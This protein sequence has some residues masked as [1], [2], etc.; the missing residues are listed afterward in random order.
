M[1]LKE[2]Q[3]KGVPVY[4]PEHNED[5]RFIFKKQTMLDGTEMDVMYRKGNPGYTM[6]E[7]IAAR[8][9][10][11]MTFSNFCPKLDPRSFEVTPG[12][13]CDRDV[14]CVLRD[15]TRIYA[16]IYR[17]ANTTEKVPVIVSWSPFGKRQSEGMGTWKLMGVPPH[18]VSQWA[19]FESPDPGYWCHQGYAIANVDP[20]GVGNSEGDSCPFTMQDGRD[21]YDFTEWVAEQEWCNGKVAY[22]GNSGV[23]M[24]IW[25]IAAEQPPHLACIAPWEGTGDMYRES[26]CVGGI[27]S[28]LFNEGI[29][30]G[31]SCNNYAEDMGNMSILHPFHDAYWES[32]T[33]RWENIRVPAYVTAGYCHFH[34]HGSIEGFR[35]I[36]STKKWLRIHREMEWPDTYHKDNVA[37]LKLFFDRYL[38]DIHNGWEFTPKI[39]TDIMDAYDFDLERNHEEREYPIA[40]TEYKKIYLDAATGTGSYTP[41]EK[42]AEIAYDP[43]KDVVSFDYQFEED[44]LLIGYMKLHLGLEVRGYDNTDIFVWVKKYS[45]DGEYRPVFC[46][47]ENY[48]GAWGY[49]RGSH[50]ELDEKLS[51]DFQPVQAHKKEEPFE[52][53][54][55]YPVDIE[56]WPHSRFWHKGERIRVEISGHFIKSEWYEDMRMHYDTDN[57]NGT[58]V[59][60]TGGK[61]DAYLQ[62]PVIPPK[63]QVG[64]YVVR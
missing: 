31:I 14:C 56:I 29:V 59:I 61:H 21:G 45:E 47:G 35:R 58:A 1:G 48:R 55:V 40:R 7:L 13:I 42:E 60:H 16:D 44:T 11:E 6:E 63:Y 33:P 41:F 10:G 52:E 24:V 62:I 20:R 39:R 9:R 43:E 5:E 22:T 8:E 4:D 34:L 30:E 12:I 50:R 25:R 3:Y 23:A 46:T 49:F 32:V 38:K 19:K 2:Q 26:V 54:Q 36:R 51:T 53:G 27:P 18:T 15:G 28:A 17:P 64:D 37:D 57:G